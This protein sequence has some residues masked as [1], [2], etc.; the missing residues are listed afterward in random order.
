MLTRRELLAGAAAVALGPPSPAHAQ[1]AR[2]AAPAARIA[3]NPALEAAV[4]KIVADAGIRPGVPGMA[5]LLMRP[6]RILLAKG[7]GTADLRTQAP[8][9]AATQFELASVTKTFTA[10]AVLTLQ[11]RGALSVNDNVRR[12]LP[13]LPQYQREPLRIGDMLHHISGL[14]D[15]FVLQNVPMRNRTYWVSEDYLPEFARQRGRFPARFP[16]GQKYE[17]SNTNFMLMSLVIARASGKSYVGFLHDEI[18]ARAGMPNSFVYMS[19]DAAL[20]AA[21]PYCNNALGYEFKNQAFV[22]SWGTPPE[23]HEQ[24]LAIGDGRVWTNLHDM[25][26][27]DTA[28]R[29]NKLIKPATMQLALTTSHTRDGKTNRYGLGWFLYSDGGGLYGFGHNGAWNGFR[30]NYYNYLTNNHT[31]VLLSNRGDAIDLEK[32][33]DKLDAAIVA[34]A[35][36]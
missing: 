19:L 16:I 9:T 5:V 8:I 21:N 26:N 24:Y 23:R 29:T 6:G 28:L 27:W 33:W 34:H 7:Y 4:D 12:F 2:P 32:V 3:P 20:R 36:A 22:E 31:V 18:F 25:V 11:E 30:T 35:K 17:Y 15:Y 1:G 10:T 14:P 13:E